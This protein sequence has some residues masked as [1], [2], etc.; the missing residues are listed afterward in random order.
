[1][2]DDFT[3]DDDLKLSSAGVDVRSVEPA[4]IKETDSHAG[5]G[6]DERGEGLAVCGYDFSTFAWASNSL[7]REGEDKISVIGEEGEAFCCGI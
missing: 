1:L 6:S 3:L 4:G 2:S 5:V 7:V